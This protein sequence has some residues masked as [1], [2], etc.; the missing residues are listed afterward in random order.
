[1]REQ[2]QDLIRHVHG[3]GAIDVVKVVGTSTETAVSAC[4][5]DRTVI[6]NGVFNSPVPELTGTLGMPNLSKLKTILGFDDYGD[7]S[8]ISVVTEQRGGVDVPTTIRFETANKDCVNNYRLMSKE[9]VESRVKTI[10]LKGT[11]SWNVE[12]TPVQANVARLKR[13]AMVHSENTTFSVRIDGS[14]L[15]V[16]FGDPANHSGNF[17]LQSGVQGTMKNSLALPIKAF[18]S[19]MDLPGEKVIR[20]SDRGVAEIVVASGISV[21]SYMLPAS[22]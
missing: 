18:L 6:I 20:L 3:I 16:H 19:I 9:L 10:E 8:V 4:S 7:G 1:M 15:K 13:Q 14:D 21:Y 17:V 5:D 12:F 2:L 11:P 22:R